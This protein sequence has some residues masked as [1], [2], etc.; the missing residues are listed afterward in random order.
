MSSQ[1]QLFDQT[2]ARAAQQAEMCR[3]SMQAQQAEA[4]LEL[5]T[6]SEAL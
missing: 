3:H 4:L 1:L 5:Q 2:V 6:G